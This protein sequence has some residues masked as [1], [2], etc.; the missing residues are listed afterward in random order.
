MGVAGHG[1]I[2]R[3]AGE[4]R[5]ERFEAGAQHR[6]ED[7]GGQ[8]AGVLTAGSGEPSHSTRL[9]GRSGGHAVSSGYPN[10]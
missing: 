2:H 10:H 4:Q 3:D 9:W 6:A 1:V 5:A 7:E 8:K